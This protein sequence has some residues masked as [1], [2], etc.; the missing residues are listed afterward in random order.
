VAP[1]G[2]VWTVGRRWVRHRPR[3]R[4]RDRDSDSGADAADA[5]SFWGDFLSFDDIT[6]AGILAA[7]AIAVAVA[8]LFLV[9]WP[10]VAIAIELLIVLLL[11]LAGIVGRVLFRR[12][13]T[14]EA[15]GARDHLTWEVPGWRASGE[16]VEDIGR[17]IVAGEDPRRIQL[18]LRNQDQLHVG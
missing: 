7:L 10:L 15:R 4:R 5:G 3:L 17:R 12:P 9:V 11:A 18:S 13:W 1:D 14:V 6:P 8:L 16:L 2:R